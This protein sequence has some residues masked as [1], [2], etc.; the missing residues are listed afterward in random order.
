MR[1]LLIL[2]AAAPLALAQGMSTGEASQDP[3]ATSQ[4][5]PAR[6]SQPVAGQETKPASPAQAT[7]A[8]E[9]KPA[10]AQQSPPAAGQETKPTTPATPAQATPAA[11]GKPPAAQQNP[12]AA[13]QETNPVPPAQST[14]AQKAAPDASQQPASSTVQQ[15]APA[16][17]PPETSPVPAGEITGA[18]WIEIGYRWR[19]DIG[20]NFD[21]YRS[22]V[23][24]GSGPKLLGTEFSITDPNHRLFDDVHVR[25][26][27]WGD[28]PYATLHLDARKRKLYD[29]AADY[30]D[31]AY[32]D[33]LPSFADPSLGSGIMLNQQS[34]DTR[35]RF[36]HFELNMLPG[37]WFS[38]YA[39]YDTDS[40]SGTGV[41]TYVANSNEYPV[42]T[43]LRDRTDNFRA[44][45]HFE[46]RRF[47]ATLEQGGTW[48]H[49]DQTVYQA[50]GV[51]LGEFD[52]APSLDKLVNLS[53]SA[54]NLRRAWHEYL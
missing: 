40:G 54:R 20:G 38:P 45:V 29:F 11:G 49:N 36:A 42:P 44:G 30:R 31:I 39:A 21:A 27:D 7:P 6:Q 3:P 10:P 1:R 19:S 23:N 5:A 32:F 34:F 43:T 13:E 51:N 26:Y 46:F 52:D 9:A 2:L 12:P 4:Q 53:R 22:L 14:P 41:T 47:H 16:A 37:N 35:R 17:A 28:D 33:F 50:S 8:Q 25:A 18:G 48:Y 24:L 15:A